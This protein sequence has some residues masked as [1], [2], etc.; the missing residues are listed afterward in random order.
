MDDPKDE[1]ELQS[2][3]LDMVE[4]YRR[5][6]E[7][8]IH[9]LKRI[10]EGALKR[11]SARK[12]RTIVAKLLDQLEV[13]VE[14]YNGIADELAP[15]EDFP[16]RGHRWPGLSRPTK[17]ASTEG[18]DRTETLVDQLHSTSESCRKLAYEI[19]SEEEFPERAD[20]WPGFFMLEL[21]IGSIPNAERGPSHN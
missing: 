15:E 21:T 3:E 16:E 13:L 18:R 2:F 14:N 7:E 9:S 19:A 1:D 17:A 4:A 11:G 12:R 20:R 8:G 10:V 6:S 5:H